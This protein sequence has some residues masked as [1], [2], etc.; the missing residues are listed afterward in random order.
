[1]HDRRKR[2]IKNSV[3]LCCEDVGS[4][5]KQILLQL[6]EADP[7]LGCNRK[8]DILEM[9]IFGSASYAYKHS[10]K[11]LDLR[12]EKWIFVGYDRN[13]PAY[14]VYDLKNSQILKHSRVKF[15]N[16][17]AEQQTQIYL[18]NDDNDDLR[19]R[20]LMKNPKSEELWRNRISRGSVKSKT[21]G[22]S[23]T[24]LDKQHRYEKFD[25]KTRTLQK[26]NFIFSINSTMAMI[27]QKVFKCVCVCVC[28]C[29]K[30]KYC[31]FNW[32]CVY[33]C[34]CPN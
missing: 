16:N 17:V 28:V 13:S 20:D 8:P 10:K 19:Q 15:I 31:Q 30:Y 27:I 18:S 11:K 34:V 5:P 14:L 1:M 3:D 4:G 12:C 9:N 23:S 24:N 26:N 29:V 25:K 32:A 22:V 7:L 6:L 2:S 21:L 33:V